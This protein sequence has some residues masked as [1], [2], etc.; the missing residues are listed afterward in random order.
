MKKRYAGRIK[1]RYKLMVWRNGDLIYKF[2]RMRDLLVWRGQSILAYLL[3]QG[4]VGT[5]TSGWK[6]VVSSNETAPDMG[7]DSGDPLNNEFNP[8][9]A[10]PVDV[11]YE[12]EPETKPSGG[13]QTFATLNIKALATITTSGTLRKIGLIDSGTPPNQY[14]I[15]EDAVVPID[16]N[17][18]DKIDIVYFI[19]LG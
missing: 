16:V 2:K 8:T 14:I 15:V 7:D 18:N 1:F 17:V 10:D 5:P 11:T 12:F 9:L 4:A 3:S 19:Q 13:Y 6:F